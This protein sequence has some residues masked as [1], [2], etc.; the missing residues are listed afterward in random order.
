MVTDPVTTLAAMASLLGLRRGDAA[1]QAA[2]QDVQAGPRL[3]IP[4]LNQ[5]GLLTG[6]TRPDG[7]AAE[8][9]LQVHN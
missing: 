8:S 1:A 2:A 3:P 6:V 4:W 5:S 7:T 9:S